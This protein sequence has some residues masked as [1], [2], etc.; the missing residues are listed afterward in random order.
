MTRLEVEEW[1]RKLGAAGHYRLVVSG[2]V[3]MFCLLC[4]R[5][6]DTEIQYAQIV[7]CSDAQK[8]DISATATPFVPDPELFPLGDGNEE[9]TKPG[10][11]VPESTTWAPFQGIEFTEK[12]CECGVDATGGGMHSSWCPKAG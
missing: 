11:T 12:K 9:V 2:R 10:R 4:H 8:M 5:K 3:F 6:W 7:Q 1:S